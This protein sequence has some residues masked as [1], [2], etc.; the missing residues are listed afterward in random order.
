[1]QG[2]QKKENRQNHIW[3]ILKQTYQNNKHKNW[4]LEKCQ[5]NV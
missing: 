5:Q 4:S 2:K 3:I 1:M